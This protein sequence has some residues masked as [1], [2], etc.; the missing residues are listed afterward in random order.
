MPR[1][2]QQAIHGSQGEPIRLTDPQTNVEYVVLPAK[3]Y[4]QI[5]GLFYDHS[6]VTSEKR[7]A[8]LTSGGFTS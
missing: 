6:P 1:E 7:R 3:M 2:L 4:N 8:L 5:K